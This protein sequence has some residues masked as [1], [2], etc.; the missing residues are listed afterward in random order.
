MTVP[1][2]RLKRKRRRKSKKKQ[3]QPGWYV[4]GPHSAHPGIGFAADF[5]G[6]GEGV[7]RDF[8]RSTLVEL[9]FDLEA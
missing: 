3:Q 9:A 7:L 1:R 6:V 8:V 2:D 5:G 4:G